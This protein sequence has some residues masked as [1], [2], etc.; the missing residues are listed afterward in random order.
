MNQIFSL[1][2]SG[3]KARTVSYFWI[4]KLCEPLGKTM[5]FCICNA[6][7]FREKDWL[8]LMRTALLCNTHVHIALLCNTH[9]YNYDV[10]TKPI[11]HSKC[12]AQFLDS[13]IYGFPIADINIAIL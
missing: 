11:L 4:F 12:G 5:H 13:S 9:M 10:N 7:R 6:R 1:W 2:R 8:K 3:N